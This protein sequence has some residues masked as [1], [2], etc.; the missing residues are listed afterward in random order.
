MQIFI[1]QILPHE[2]HPNG[3]VSLQYAFQ[4]QQTNVSDHLNDVSTNESLADNCGEINGCSMQTSYTNDFGLIC[5]KAH[6]MTRDS[7]GRFHLYSMYLAHVSCPMYIPKNALYPK[8]NFI[9]WSFRW[10]NLWL[11]P[12]TNWKATNYSLVLLFYIS[13]PKFRLNFGKR[14]GL[15]TYGIKKFKIAG[16]QPI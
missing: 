7:L 12:R 16:I 6:I 11:A 4:N 3:T 13:M 14:F 10:C 1:G 9:W 2:C 8:F 15:L 5:D